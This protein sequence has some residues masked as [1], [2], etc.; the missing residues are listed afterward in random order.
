MRPPGSG[1]SAEKVSTFRRHLHR[2]LEKGET[3]EL[4]AWGPVACRNTLQAFATCPK[5]VEFQL[6]W[7]TKE[8]EK[9][10]CLHFIAKSFLP[11][12]EYLQTRI[13]NTK[14]IPVKAETRAP[15]L[16]RS[17]CSVLE[18]APPES[19]AMRVYASLE[20]EAAVAVLAKGLASAPG[21][22]PFKGLKCICNIVM[23]MEH[24][25]S[26][27][28]TYVTFR[29][30]VAVPKV[31][32]KEFQ[33]YPSGNI[34]EEAKRRFTASVQDRLHMGYE[35]KMSCRA[36]A[37]VMQAIRSFCLLK[38][39]VAEFRVS[40]TSLNPVANDQQTSKSSSS[41][42][43]L[44]VQAVRGPSWE[45]FNSIDFSN[46]RLLKA[47]ATTPVGKLAY[48]TIAEVRLHGAVSIHCFSDNLDNVN[49]VM[50]ALATVSSISGK[51]FRCFPSFGRTAP[52]GDPVL[53]VYVLRHHGSIESAG[54][55]D[56]NKSEPSYA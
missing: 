39:H 36:A 21:L 1:A 9:E 28:F 51:Q 49:A 52:V 7:M 33:V 10:R 31:S 5:A 42:R 22:H 26:R 3:V 16:A 27:L 47:T 15:A 25:V 46:S 41:A 53:R 18:S 35:V 54:D 12:E 11:W 55:R 32:Y 19:Q 56:K 34:D 20:D 8:S 37:D 2:T 38:G 40:W 29:D 6:D 30:E 23:P 4:S 44:W 45:D 17:I 50:K 14:S 13:M 24:P 48:A 43:A